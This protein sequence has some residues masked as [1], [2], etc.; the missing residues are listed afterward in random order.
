MSEA[1]STS[2]RRPPTIDLTAKEVASSG[3]DPKPD[4]EAASPQSKPEPVEE[5][6][7]GAGE[8]PPEVHVRPLVGGRPE[9]V[10][11]LDRFRTEYPLL[12]SKLRL[13]IYTASNRP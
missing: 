6:A 4:S 2:R 9:A 1:D 3:P 10:M 11:T 8:T 7:A 13:V 5:P 12:R